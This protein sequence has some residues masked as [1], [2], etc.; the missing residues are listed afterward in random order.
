VKPIVSDSSPLISWAR[1]GKL[2]LLRRL[3]KELVVPEAVYK[4]VVIDGKGKPGAEDVERAAW[5]RRDQVRQRDKVDD[6]S[7]RFGP[8]ES[9]AI[10]L[11]S[12]MGAILLIDE[13]VC[14]V[15]K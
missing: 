13:H 15:R 1:A 6:L 10:A 4:E 14:G 2:E 5:V 8:G 3:I 11:A 9:E 7:R 12:E